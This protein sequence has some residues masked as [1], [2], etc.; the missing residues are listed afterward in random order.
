MGGLSLWATRL[1]KQANDAVTAVGDVNEYITRRLYT[2]QFQQRQAEQAMSAELTK[3][4]FDYTILVDAN[5]Q[6]V[7][8]CEERQR[9]AEE[10]K[11]LVAAAEDAQK[12]AKASEQRAEAARQAAEDALKQSEEQRKA[13]VD[14]AV[15]SATTTLTVEKEKLVNEVASL[16]TEILKQK[17]QAMAAFEDG[18]GAT[19]EYWEEAYAWAHGEDPQVSLSLIQ[20]YVKWLKLKSNCALAGMDP[21]SPFNADEEPDEEEAEEGVDD[22]EYEEEEEEEGGAEPSDDEADK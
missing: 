13:I 3:L 9:E 18:E 15:A 11:S 12:S 1:R 5:K 14:A 21:P 19:N 8:R 2:V 16:N 7:E 10:A 6:L 20:R 22:E 4:K 17:E